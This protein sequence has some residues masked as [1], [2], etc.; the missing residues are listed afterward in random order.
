LQSRRA[1]LPHFVKNLEKISATKRPRLGKALTV[2]EQS[3]VS[4]TVLTV[5]KTE[6]DLRVSQEMKLF[7]ENFLFLHPDGND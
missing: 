6:M 5:L 7:C 4:R 2:G 3:F 1:K